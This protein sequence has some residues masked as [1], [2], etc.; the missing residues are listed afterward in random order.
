[1]QGARGVCTR[2]LLGIGHLARGS[3]GFPPW[4]TLIVPLLLALPEGE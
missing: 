1:M 3:F 4:S 2:V